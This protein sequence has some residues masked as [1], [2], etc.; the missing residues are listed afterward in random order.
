MTVAI[1]DNGHRFQTLRRVYDEELTAAIEKL[2]VVDHTTKLD[3]QCHHLVTT[4]CNNDGS[5]VNFTYKRLRNLKGLGRIKGKR[6]VDF[7]LP[8]PL[9]HLDTDMDA[10]PHIIDL[11]VKAIHFNVNRR[12]IVNLLDFTSVFSRNSASKPSSPAVDSVAPS[13][14]VAE[15]ASA[16]KSKYQIHMVLGQLGVSLIQRSRRIV[17]F[18]ISD[19][20]AVA[21]RQAEAVLARGHLG[22]MTVSDK[23]EAGS[24]YPSVFQ[25]SGSHV[26]TFEVL[27]RTAQRAPSVEVDW[28][29]TSVKIRM[30]SVRYVHTNRFLRLIS[31]YVATFRAMQSLLATV[32]TVAQDLIR[33]DNHKTS[34]L[35]LDIEIEKPIMILPRHS[36]SMDT[37]E[38][39]IER[40]TVK[41]VRKVHDCTRIHISPSLARLGPR[42][43]GT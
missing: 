10:V 5:F 17:D 25:T 33:Q 6:S 36:L 7:E 27:K 12:T 14:A 37:V 15:P 4:D 42:N 1:T 22:G 8:E 11:S 3:S 2:V 28:F 38:A 19:L 16:L 39:E 32:K 34:F 31:T 13:S 29:S 18:D 35:K 23:T 40:M 43:R 26:L 41:N 24:F 20:S 9:S 21:F 30:A